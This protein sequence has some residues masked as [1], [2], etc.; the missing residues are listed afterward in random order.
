MILTNYLYRIIVARFKTITF[1]YLLKDE[2]LEEFDYIKLYDN[3]IQISDKLN[4]KVEPVMS[5]YYDN[6]MFHDSKVLFYYFNQTNFA[7]KYSP[8]ITREILDTEMRHMLNV[9]KDK[10]VSK[11]ISNK[12]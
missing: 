6:Y 5:F 8:T 7:I 1:V 11:Y 2:K 9:V 10:L 3:S 12:S 4:K